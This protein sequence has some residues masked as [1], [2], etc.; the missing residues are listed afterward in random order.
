MANACKSMQHSVF[1]NMRCLKLQRA[2]R[3]DLMTNLAVHRHK[4]KGGFL[5]A[6]ALDMLVPLVL[7]SREH[8]VHSHGII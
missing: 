8:E 5:V 7:K 1:H 4:R 3:M 6:S 2:V